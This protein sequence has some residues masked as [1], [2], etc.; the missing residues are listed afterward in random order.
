MATL[1]HDHAA[2]PFDLR[3]GRARARARACAR[4]QRSSA[5]DEPIDR[6]VWRRQIDALAAQGQRV[7][8][9]AIK[10]APARARPSSTCADVEGGLTLLGL[11]GLID[12]PR[13]EAV[14]AVRR[15]PRGRH[16]R[17]DDHRRPCRDRARRSRGSSG[18]ADDPRVDRPARDRS[19]WTMPAL[20]RVARDDVRLR[21]HQ[22][23]AQAAAGRGACRPR[24]RWSR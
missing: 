11:V 6:R 19:R 8:G 16:R 22:P 15:M 20:R 13:P 17:Q 10:A 3:Q 4:R 14:A 2:A 24:A 23:R 12:P 18:L 5:G 9:F 1:H 7:L 21:P